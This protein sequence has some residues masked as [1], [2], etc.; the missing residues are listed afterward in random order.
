MLGRLEETLLSAIVGLGGESYSVEIHDHVQTH[1]N[2][3]YSAGT[4]LT[5]LY[6]MEEKGFVSSR[7]S[8][9]VPERG[10]RRKRMF[11]IE[12]A[13]QQALRETEVLAA[14]KSNNFA[15]VLS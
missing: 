4:L 10:G 9:P 11:K 12:A 13:G 1:T 5:T 6:R 14:L 3:D 8:D 15:P 7:Y 2:K